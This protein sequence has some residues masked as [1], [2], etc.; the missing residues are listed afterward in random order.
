[1]ILHLMSIVEF[2]GIISPIKV[3]FYSYFLH[4]FKKVLPE[5]DSVRISSIERLFKDNFLS[6]KIFCNHCFGYYNH[7]RI[8]IDAFQRLTRVF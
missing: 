7:I 4:I 6:G 5:E 1:M 2:F 8:F 3:D